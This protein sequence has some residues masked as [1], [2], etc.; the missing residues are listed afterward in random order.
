MSASAE[1]IQIFYGE[2]D[3]FLPEAFPQRY[4]NGRAFGLPPG[5]KR[6]MMNGRTPKSKRRPNPYAPDAERTVTPLRLWANATG[7]PGQTSVLEDPVQS[8]QSCSRGAEQLP[9]HVDTDT[10]H[11]VEM[12]MDSPLTEVDE[13]TVTRGC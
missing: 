4:R 7:V 3:Y 1:K 12:L 5:S 6:A 8:S 13:A 9:S 10:A 2:K 11:D